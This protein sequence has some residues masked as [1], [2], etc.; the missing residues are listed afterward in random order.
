MSRSYKKAYVTENHKSEAKKRANKIIRK[1]DIPNGKI[2]K[3]FFETWNITDFRWR[4]DEDNK[5]YKKYTRK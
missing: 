1:M 3:K 5:D 4:V 2:Y